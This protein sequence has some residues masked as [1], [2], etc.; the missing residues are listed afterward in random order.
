MRDNGDKNF[1]PCCDSRTKPTTHLTGE[2]RQQVRQQLTRVVS[3]QSFDLVG[4]VYEMAAGAPARVDSCLDALV[5]ILAPLDDL[6]KAADTMARADLRFGDIDWD[7]KELRRYDPREDR[8]IAARERVLTIHTPIQDLDHRTM[9]QCLARLAAAEQMT[10]SNDDYW[11]IHFDGNGEELCV[12]GRSVQLRNH[13]CRWR[14]RPTGVRCAKGSVAR[15][16]DRDAGDPSR[17]RSATP[18][19]G[20]GVTRAQSCD[21]SVT[22]MFH[23]DHLGPPTC[24]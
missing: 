17:V 24:L 2:L 19:I 8:S 16:V 11:R 3:R 12:L 13:P 5:H 18:R 7:T 9:E 10:D 1:S 22:R 23:A 4:N 14:R 20:A 15:L 6:E 21:G